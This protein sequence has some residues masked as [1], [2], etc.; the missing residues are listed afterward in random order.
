MNVLK[1]LAEGGFK[2]VLAAKGVPSALI[3]AGVQ[4]LKEY[5][6]NR[7]RKN[8]EI[9]F[10]TCT[11]ACESEKKEWAYLSEVEHPELVGELLMEVLES[12]I[13]PLKPE[14]IARLFAAML[15][16]QFGLEPENAHQKFVKLAQMVKEC[17]SVALAEL[18]KTPTRTEW[19]FNA[20]HN[21]GNPLQGI[22]VASGFLSN[23]GTNYRMTDEAAAI[24]KFGFSK[25]D[26]FSLNPS[27]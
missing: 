23:Y 9:F 11:E 2:D 1:K 4:A 15:I 27:H 17:S 12:S 14:I 3:D 7:Y 10:N 5:R 22:L 18:A 20:Q 13:D 26:T 24:R 19:D 16:T 8:L 25:S 6:S 21:H